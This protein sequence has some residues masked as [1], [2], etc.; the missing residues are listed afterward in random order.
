MNEKRN[1]GK[2]WLYW[3][4]LGVAIIMVY[5][6]LDNFSDVMNGFNKFLNIITPFFG[7]I[8]IAYLFY[9]PC[10]KFEEAYKKSKI[11]FVSKKSRAFGIFSVYLIALLLIVILIN[12]ILPVVFKSITDLI[13]NIQGY[14]EIAINKYNSLPDDSIFKGDIVNDTI[15]SIQ[16]LDIKQY[17]KLDKILEYIASALSAV[18]GVFDVFVA[19]VVSV[20]VLSERNKILIFLKKCAKAIF[21]EETYKNV[22]KYFNNSNEIFFKFIAS[23]FLDAVVVGILVTIALTIMKIKYAPL[24]GFFIG[25][26]NMIPYIGAI[27]AVG[28]SAIITLITGGF[29]Q[30]VWMLIVTIIL[31]QID[32]NI[33]NPKITGQSLEISPLLVI[34]SVTLGGAYFGMLGMF[35][36]VPVIAIIKII[37]EDYLDYKVKTKKIESKKEEENI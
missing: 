27:I 31:Q 23:Q 30:A 1:Y 14:Y 19:I 33:I 8:F 29:S 24:L 15:K 34:F 10:S 4:A 12:V 25:L 26:F 37:V 32:A 18:V 6:A 16:G 36:A 28:L 3:F 5:K 21:K 22:D 35:L 17:F 13:N 2:R 7:G 20:Y 9:I 11:K